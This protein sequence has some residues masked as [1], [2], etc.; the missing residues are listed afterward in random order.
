M[1]RPLRLSAVLVAGVVALAACAAPAPAPAAPGDPAGTVT[2]QNCG[3]PRSS[4]RRRSA[5][6]STTAT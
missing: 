3:A 4:R 2:V 6:S 5:S 1:T